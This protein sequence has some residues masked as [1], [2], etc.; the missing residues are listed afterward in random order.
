MMYFVHDKKEY[1]LVKDI[2]LKTIAESEACITGVAEFLRNIP[3][4][5][6]TTVHVRHQDC[7]YCQLML[8]TISGNNKVFY[9]LLENG[10]F[11]EKLSE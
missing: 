1:E 5:D 9:W 3:L 8:D 4:S 6:L 10:F 7:K 2:T 11:K